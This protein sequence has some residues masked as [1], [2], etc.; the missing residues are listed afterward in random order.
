MATE[1]SWRGQLHELTTGTYGKGEFRPPF[2]WPGCSPD[3]EVVLLTAE[4][5][6][7]LLAENAQLM[8]DVERWKGDAEDWENAARTT[9][10]ESHEV[11]SEL[12]SE[13]ANRVEDAM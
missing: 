11:T 2:D 5:Y 3:T 9:A 6:E 12:H 7:A 8:D 4:H 1:H 13:L 10:A